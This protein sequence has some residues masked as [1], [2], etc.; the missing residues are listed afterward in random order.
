[1]GRCQRGYGIYAQGSQ[2]D[3]GIDDAQDE[4]EGKNGGYKLRDSMW[5]PDL[6]EYIDLAFVNAHKAGQAADAKH[7]STTMPAMKLF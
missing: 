6:P 1:M 2:A 7:N 5:H 3:L 4:A